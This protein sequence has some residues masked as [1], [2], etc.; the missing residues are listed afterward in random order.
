ML[1]LCC[2]ASGSISGLSLCGSVSRFATRSSASLCSRTLGSVGGTEASTAS[3]FAARSLNSRLGLRL[4]SVP[5]LWGALVALRLRRT[6]ASRLGHCSSRFSS[7]SLYSR[8]LGSVGSTQLCCYASGS[9]PGLSIRDSVFGFSLFQ[10]SGERWQHR[11]FDGLSLCGSVTVPL[12][13]NQRVLY[14]VHVNG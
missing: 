11:G 5:E 13:L 6:L 12:V 14:S 2:Y 4:F 9:V 10:N 7:A 3:R 1:A 8:T